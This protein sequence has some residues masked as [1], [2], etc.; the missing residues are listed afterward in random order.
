MEKITLLGTAG[1]VTNGARDNVSLVLTS[2]DVHVLIECG[3]SA[4]HKL[5]R[6]G[7]AYET[8]QDIILTHTHLD[9]FYGLPAYVFSTRYK[10]VNRTTPLR[11]YVP[12]P[13]V[14]DVIALLDCFGLRAAPFFP[15][16]VRGIP[17]QEHVEVLRN[18]RM[19]ITATPV[20]HSTE[21]PACG[22]KMVSQ[23]SGRTFV[24]SSDTGPSER[25][26]RF[27]AGV[28]VLFHECAG[29]AKHPIP[30]IHSNALQVGE[31]ARMCQVQKLV[32]LHLD[33]V[34]HDDPLA[35][36]AEVRQNFQGEVVV[37]SDFDEY[38]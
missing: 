20:D 30:A 14:Q 19:I 11:V 25:L 3:G 16:D 10:N 4:A 2:G 9:H 6:V 33:M 31:I 15:I 7:I 18:E 13:S 26:I 21:H 1:A 24:Y 32:L 36:I 37:A 38:L 17:L 12:E 29:L 23:T 22:I 27:A 28:D 34:C 8:L 5:A 35:I